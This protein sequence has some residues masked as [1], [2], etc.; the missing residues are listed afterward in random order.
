MTTSQNYIGVIPPQWETH[1][2]KILSY[3]YGNQRL[4][5]IN[6][7]MLCRNLT[8]RPVCPQYHWHAMRVTF[9]CPWGN[10]QG[11][12]IT[13][14]QPECDRAAMAVELCQIGLNINVGNMP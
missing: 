14:I 4:A 13:F 7:K 8:V 2:V 6:A 1:N 11:L 5:R 9:G 3:R 10:W 12:N